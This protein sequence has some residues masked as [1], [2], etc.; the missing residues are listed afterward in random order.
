MRRLI[1]LPF[2]CGVIAAAGMF[3]TDAQSQIYYRAVLVVVASLTA[4]SSFFTSRQFDRNDKL[5]LSW[6]LLGV[7]YAIAA[8]RYL[9]RI[10][11]LVTGEGITN[12]IFLNALLIL[13]NLLVPV[14]LYLFVRAWH[15]TGLAEPG[16]PGARYASIIAGIAVAVVVGG[17]PLLRGLATANADLVGLVSTLGDM[18]SIALIVP[19]MMPA[20]ALRGGL[21]MHTW[22]YLTAGIVAWLVYD[23]WYALRTTVPIPTST[24]RGI[25]EGIRVV[26]IMFACIASIAQRRAIKA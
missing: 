19:L 17:F 15:A 16:S 8:I 22:S 26:A 14:A 9:I 1:L 10:H 7:G 12:P 25:E 3:M 20:L 18:V 13:Q 6:F 4:I 23:I 2:A 21:L 11:T 5:Y 24:Q